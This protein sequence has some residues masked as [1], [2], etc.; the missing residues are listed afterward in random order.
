MNPHH[1]TR[2]L[3][4]Q[5]VLVRFIAII[6]VAIIQL[7][8][9]CSS[10]NNTKENEEAADVHQKRAL[11]QII[12]HN[13]NNFPISDEL[14]VNSL[15]KLRGF[16][17]ET[18]KVVTDDKYILTIHRLINPLIETQDTKGVIIM[19]H[20]ILCSSSFYLISSWPK[21]DDA[22]QSLANRAYNDDI[23]D[24]NN[25]AYTLSN[26]GYDVWLTN[27]RGNQYSNQHLLYGHSNRKFWNFTVDSLVYYDY[28]AYA[29]YILN[30][31]K[32]T[33]YTFIGH[34]LGAT[35]GLGSLLAHKNTRITNNLACSILMAPVASTK[36]VKGNLIPLFRMATILYDELAPFPGPV[37]LHSIFLEHVCT[38]FKSL[39]YWLAE[40]FTGKTC[41]KGKRRKFIEMF[42]KNYTTLVDNLNLNYNDVHHHDSKN[43]HDYDYDAND[44][45]AHK[46]I[47]IHVLKQSISVLALKHIVQVHMSG[48][49]SQFDYGPEHNQRV[50]G[51]ELPPSYDLTEIYEPN[52]KV[53][54]INGPSDA[55]STMDEINWIAEQINYRVGKIEKISAPTEK[56]NHLDLV[57]SNEAGK[58]VN[59]P[60]VEFIERNKCF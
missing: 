51:T 14:D 52:L 15:A 33:K 13:N 9:N 12:H 34:S 37:G 11:F 60:I 26:L 35:V 38:Y 5:V 19:Q 29:N 57:L 18:H 40:T 8:D 2:A 28:K 17:I 32:K 44:S 20:G 47:F 7:T 54:L 27:F 10:L 55:I 30:H 21:L 22:K 4:R 42:S 31:T 56:F 16:L 49:L 3:S 48:R 1:Q 58:L 46:F 36:F 39:C 50:Y 45:R 24:G 23:V 25:L 59:K 43:D 53:A 41:V 6:V